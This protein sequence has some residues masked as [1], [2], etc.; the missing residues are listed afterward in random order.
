MQIFS[1][2]LLLLLLLLL[3]SFVFFLSLSSTPFPTLLTHSLTH[4]LICYLTNE[5]GIQHIFVFQMADSCIQVAGRVIC[6]S[7]AGHSMA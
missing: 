2:S 3:L 7:R 5:L 4:P 1:L 6:C